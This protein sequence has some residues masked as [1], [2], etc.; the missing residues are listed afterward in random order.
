MF[1]S[2]GIGAIR[3]AVS[4][5]EYELGSNRFLLSLPLR[6]ENDV[7]KSVVLSVGSFA[8]LDELSFFLRVSKVTESIDCDEPVACCHVRPTVKVDSDEL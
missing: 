4:I 7:G 2:E 6:Y 5:K 1:V 8:V 3:K